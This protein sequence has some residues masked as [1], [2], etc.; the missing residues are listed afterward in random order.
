MVSANIVKAVPARFIKNNILPVCNTCVF[1]EPMVP[2]SMKMPRCNKFGEKN[3]ITGKITYEPAEH[4]RQ[5]Q[6]LCGTV[7]N[8]YLENA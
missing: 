1:F 7:G 3:I 8:Y 6:N 2:K 5:N 4:C